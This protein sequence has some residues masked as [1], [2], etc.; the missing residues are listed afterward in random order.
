[1]ALIIIV[2]VLVVN[3]R[4]AVDVK[5]VYETG[6]P[7]PLFVSRDDTNNSKQSGGN[8]AVP[9]S[10]GSV[11]SVASTEGVEVKVKKSKTKPTKDKDRKTRKTKRRG[12]GGESAAASPSASSSAGEGDAWSPNPDGLAPDEWEQALE[13]FFRKCVLV[14]TCTRV[15]LLL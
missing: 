3:K 8:I 12:D 10:P 7:P 2:V 13:T 6:V 5:R 14:Y 15:A 11:G 9:P 4:R 1:M